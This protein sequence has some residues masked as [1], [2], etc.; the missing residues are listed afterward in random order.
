LKS[1]CRVGSTNNYG[2]FVAGLGFAASA[3][4]FLNFDGYLGTQRLLD[5]RIAGRAGRKACLMLLLS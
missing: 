4:H 1:F 3:V 2:Y 5:S